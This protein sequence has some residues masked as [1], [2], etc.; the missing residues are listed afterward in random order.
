MFAGLATALGPALPGNSVKIVV[1]ET[2]AASEGRAVVA[3]SVGRKRCLRSSADDF[4]G[5]LPHAG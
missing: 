3:A 4:R 2:A 5:A 1:G